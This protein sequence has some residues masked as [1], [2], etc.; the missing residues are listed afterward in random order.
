[1]P[2]VVVYVKAE[3]AKSLEGDGE[4]VAAWIRGLVL[5]ALE[6][7]KEAQGG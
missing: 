6:R 1:M 5:R 7:R 4:N 3:D 2:K